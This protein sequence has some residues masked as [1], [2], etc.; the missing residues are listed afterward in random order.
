[1]TASS[2]GKLLVAN[3]GLVV[4]GLAGVELFVLAID[5]SLAVVEMFDDCD[6]MAV[7]GRS[8]GW[9]LTLTGSVATKIANAHPVF[10]VKELTNWFIAKTLGYSTATTFLVLLF[11]SCPLS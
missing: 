4:D 1:M 3:A 9:A 6:V 5:R 11:L 2:G 8:W 10:R 7:W